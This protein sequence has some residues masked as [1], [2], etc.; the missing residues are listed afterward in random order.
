M[1][2]DLFNPPA[3]FT[4]PGIDAR[5]ENLLR[6][7]ASEIEPT[8][9]E[10]SAAA[11]SQR[12]LRELLKTGHFGRRVEDVHLSGSY[13]RDTAITPLGDVDIIVLVDPLEWPKGF[14]AR[15]PDVN[16]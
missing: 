6:E 9:K 8:H 7:L 13:A 11:R 3:R 16:K 14:L 15:Y 5:T 1:M 10:K 12:H 4:W 2:F